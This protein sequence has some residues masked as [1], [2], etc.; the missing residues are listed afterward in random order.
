MADKFALPEAKRAAARRHFE[1]HGW[2]VVPDFLFADAAHRWY[3]RLTGDEM[4]DEWFHACQ[5]HDARHTLYVQDTP[6]NMAR[7]AANR[8]AAAIPAADA[9]VRYSFGRTVD[10]GPQRNWLLEEIHA[11]FGSAE[12]TAAAAAMTGL[13]ITALEAMF[14]TRMVTGDFIQPHTDAGGE[15]R[16]ASFHLNLTP[17]WEDVWGGR[18]VVGSTAVDVPYNGLL[19]IDL[20]HGGRAT[21]TTPVSAATN[22]ARVGLFGWLKSGP[23]VV[24]PG[25]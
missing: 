8:A 19:V 22:H 20:R 15:A 23:R 10:E 21:H 18:V 6:R 11:F 4:V 17:K 16:Q 2:A 12:F 24:Y 13:P 3:T 5:V 7:V 9:T 14:A 25:Q 1:E